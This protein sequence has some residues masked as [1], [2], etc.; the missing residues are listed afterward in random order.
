VANYDRKIPFGAIVAGATSNGDKIFI[1]RVKHSP[2]FLS[3]FESKYKVIN[4]TSTKLHNISE[5]CEI[6]VDRK[7]IKGKL[8]SI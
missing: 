8:W 4:L 7:V 6:L 1:G 3:Y 5:F 2:G